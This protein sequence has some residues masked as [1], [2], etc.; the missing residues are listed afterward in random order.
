MKQKRCGVCEHYGSSA[1]SAQVLR[2]AQYFKWTS[3]AQV[4]RQDKCSSRYQTCRRGDTAD[5]RWKKAPM[6]RFPAYLPASFSFLA[7]VSFWW[8]VRVG[9]KFPACS[10][11]K[12]T[13]CVENQL[14]SR[15]RCLRL[16]AA[17]RERLAAFTHLVIASRR[18]A[19]Q[20]SAKHRNFEDEERQK[21][22]SKEQT[23]AA[24]QAAFRQELC[25]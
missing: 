18:Y 3:G 13:K 6:W 16:A 5:A 21:T 17:I 8:L 14:R 2:T 1:N 20:S 12:V 19:Y 23:R 25:P 22:E 7:F 15:M 11:G 24:L 9:R 4:E 10:G